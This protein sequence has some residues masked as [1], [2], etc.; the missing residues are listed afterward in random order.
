VEDGPPAPNACVPA[1]LRA[2]MDAE[3]GLG[4]LRVMASERA[5][6]P[7]RLRD[8][9]PPGPI[10]VGD[11]VTLLPATAPCS[12]PNRERASWAVAGRGASA[13]PSAKSGARSM[14]IR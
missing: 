11:P 8:A 6:L 3:P 7:R 13:Q 12:S 9:G 14:K 2:E 5:S 10:R 1:P 4:I